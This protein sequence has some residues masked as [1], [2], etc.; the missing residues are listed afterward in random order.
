MTANV[1]KE[2]FDDLMESA[3]NAED[4]APIGM[5]IFSLEVAKAK[6]VALQLNSEAFERQKMLAHKII[7][8]NG[9]LPPPTILPR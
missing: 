9:K 8:A 1:F 4:G 5:M 3:L 2:R 7:P 6:C